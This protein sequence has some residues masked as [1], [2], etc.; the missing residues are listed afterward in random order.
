MTTAQAFGLSRIGQVAVRVRAIDRAVE[1]YRDRLGMQLLFQVPG[2]AFFQCGDVTL[3]LGLAESPEFD[4]PSSVI[5]YVVD[6]IESA[7]AA[8]SARGVPFRG[9]PH[10]IHRAPDHDLWMAFFRDPDDNT[11]A[12]MCRKARA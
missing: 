5:Y 4:H 12:L 7:Y 9:E 10:L 6:D 1:F 3:M 8:L 2:M 11:L